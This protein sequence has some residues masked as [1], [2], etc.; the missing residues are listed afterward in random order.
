M[1]TRGFTKADVTEI[2]KVYNMFYQTI[3]LIGHDTVQALTLSTGLPFS[4]LTKRLRRIKKAFNKKPYDVNNLK[5]Q[6][7]LLLKN[8]IIIQNSRLSA[9]ARKNDSSILGKD[10][11]YYVLILLK[12]G[13]SLKSLGKNGSK[14]NFPALNQLGDTVEKAINSLQ[15]I[16]LPKEEKV[17]IEKEEDE[18]LTALI[19]K[20]QDKKN[21]TEQFQERIHKADI[22]TTQQQKNKTIATE[23]SAC[24]NTLHH[25]LKIKIYSYNATKIANELKSK[26]TEAEHILK[27]YEA[28]NTNDTSITD[29]LA[30]LRT[31]TN[32]ANTTIT[33]ITRKI[34]L[35]NDLSR[36]ID[37]LDSMYADTEATNADAISPPTPLPI[38]PERYEILYKQQKQI[39]DK[40]NFINKSTSFPTNDSL[41]NQVANTLINLTDAI[42]EEA[43]TIGDKILETPIEQMETSGLTQLINEINNHQKRLQDIHSQIIANKS[44]TSIPDN[45]IS[46]QTTHKKMEKIEAQKNNLKTRAQEI[47]EKIAYIKN[48]I[49]AK[50]SLASSLRDYINGREKKGDWFFST[51][52]KS[53]KTESANCLI[54]MLAEGEG[55]NQEKIV[56]DEKQLGALT[57]GSLGKHIED[58]VLN[59]KNSP[60]AKDI[61]P[62]ALYEKIQTKIEKNK[63]KEE[64]KKNFQDALVNRR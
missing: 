40:L 61:L 32:N 4:K 51:Y 1:K 29:S 59:E 23:I 5:R 43:I 22:A 19:Q 53:D 55:K 47:N 41:S 38:T 33:N 13:K 25:I 10:N 21:F 44:D 12:N 18:T 6:A 36:T 60:Y 30:T 42:L 26:V 15:R 45:D 8:L 56:L 24:I 50:Q 63:D 52:K 17:K 46:I 3:G 2:A 20:H 27:K 37:N 39:S 7:N 14:Q 49:Q 11:Q 28:L 9:I 16:L 31:L 57:E 62:K 54:N 48:K 64:D 58:W 35:Q 34:A